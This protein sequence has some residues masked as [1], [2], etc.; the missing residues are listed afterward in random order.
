[1]S[2]QAALDRYTKEGLI[3]LLREEKKSRARGKKL[4]I[5][6][7]EYTQPILF[8]TPNVRRVQERA[9]EKE[10]FEKSERIRI[11]TKKATQAENK[12]RKEAE[13]AAKAL[14]AAVR[15]ENIDEVRAEEKAEKQ[16]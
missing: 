3:E 1:M 13:K 2:T 11:D 8:S 10:A 5:L 15:E 9:A 16:A 4:N 6:G 7:E 14:Q 12:A